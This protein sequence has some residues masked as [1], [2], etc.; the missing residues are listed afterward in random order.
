MLPFVWDGNL[1]L[2]C[3]WVFCTL[4]AGRLKGGHLLSL[5]PHMATGFQSNLKKK[6][7][8]V[9]AQWLRNLTKNHEIAGSIP[10]LT[11]C[12]KDPALL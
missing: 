5:G 7:V 10:G 1:P 12:V 9:V 3:L 8:P 2:T 6:G 4:P 11:Q